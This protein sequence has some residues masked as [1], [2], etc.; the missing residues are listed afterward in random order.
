M[1]RPGANRRATRGF[2]ALAGVLILSPDQM[3]QTVTGWFRGDV[4]YDAGP[5]G[6]WQNDGSAGN[7]TESTAAQVPTTGTLGSIATVEFDG[8]DD[9]LSTT[10]DNVDDYITTTGWTV[11]G[12]I[13][14]G[15]TSSNSSAGTPYLNHILVGDNN[16][17]WG[18]DCRTT[19]LQAY[20]WQSGYRYTDPIAIPQDVG[21]FFMSWFDGS[22]V[23]MSTQGVEETVAS[24]AINGSLSGDMCLGD[25]SSGAA[26]DVGVGELCIWS[27]ALSAQE[28]LGFQN[29]IA[30]TRS[31]FGVTP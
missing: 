19:G 14:R 29:Y 20:Q 28:R 15:A 5:P 2:G 22:T 6:D 10:T 23:Y 17:N 7:V 25:T 21:I 13:R 11:G 9:Q 27:G 31:G 26:F 30:I 12:V 16:N 18:V 4:G 8:T 24:G 3:S 1:R